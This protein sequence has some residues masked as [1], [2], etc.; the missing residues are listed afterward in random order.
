LNR[1]ENRLLNRAANH[2][3]NGQQRNYALLQ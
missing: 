2:I 1:I 3:E